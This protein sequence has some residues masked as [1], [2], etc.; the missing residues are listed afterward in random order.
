MI[1]RLVKESLRTLS[2]TTYHPLGWS[3]GRLHSILRRQGLSEE[4]LRIEHNCPVLLVHGIFHNSTAFFAIDRTLKKQGF[5]KLSSLELWTSIRSIDRMSEQLKERVKFLY[6]ENRKTN[7]QGKVRIIA[8]SLGGII[9]RAALR[10]SEFASYI[11][12]IIFLGVPHQG[13]ILY[14]FSYPK[15]VRDLAPKSP[16]MQDLKAQPLPGGIQYWN[17]RGTFDIITPSKDT[18][19]PHVPNLYFEGIGHAGLLTASRVLQA[20]L[21]ILET[22]LYEL[23][24]HDVKQS[25]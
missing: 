14:K 15:C 12:K 8:H 11:D 23:P 20:I 13:N 9:L 25:S 21:A 3:L 17:L 22:P 5:A 2:V 18:L 24:L 7:P 4:E 19:L 10:D 1:L 6:L 16:L